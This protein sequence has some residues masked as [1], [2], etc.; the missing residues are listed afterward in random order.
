MFLQTVD[1]IALNICFRFP[2]GRRDHGWNIDVWNI[3]T[4]FSL[5][6]RSDMPT[7]TEINVGISEA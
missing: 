7:T 4:Q 5:R 2:F 6:F 1:V 3:P